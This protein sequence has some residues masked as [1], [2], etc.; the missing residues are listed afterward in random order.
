M[1]L[2]VAQPVSAAEHIKKGIR[3]EPSPAAFVGTSLWNSWISI[4]HKICLVRF[5]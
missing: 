2:R 4:L 5:S 3:M 1:P